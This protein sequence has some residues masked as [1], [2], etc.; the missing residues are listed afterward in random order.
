MI[1]TTRSRPAGLAVTGA[2]ALVLATTT[3]CGAI[4]RERS[5]TSAGEPVLV[6][7]PE[8]PETADPSDPIETPDPDPDPDA[9]PVES[10]EAEP[11]EA[12]EAGVPGSDPAPSMSEEELAELEAELDDLDRLL[13]DI[14]ADLADD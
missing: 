2:L 10:A 7:S 12:S 14:E 11:A 5:G 6:T 4:D 1:A 3:G 9:D 8:E 13:G